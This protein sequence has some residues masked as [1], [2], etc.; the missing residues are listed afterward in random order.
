MIKVYGAKAF[1]PELKG[2]IRDIRVTWLLEEL[3]VPYE[4]TVLDPVT[5]ENRT[6]E[7]LALNPTGKVPTL[8]DGETVLFE[9]GAICE[10]L[11]EKYGQLIPERN[12][13]AYY[14]ARQW[15][16]WFLTN[17]EPQCLRIF[18]SDYFI[19]PGQTAAEIKKM[20]LETLP[21]LLGVLEDRLTRHEFMLQSGFSVTDILAV[22][23]LMGIFHCEILKGYPHIRTYL[24][25]CQSRP[26]YL[27]AFTQNGE[28]RERVLSE[29][30]EMVADANL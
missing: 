15:N 29:Q 9:S 5:G 7:Y 16:Y 10:Y 28:A 8:V 25:R 30:V 2:K 19:E 1:R 17:L 11:A 3:G 20:A 6:P 23:S 12:S 4:R 24:D 26:A 22:T 21:R 18:S 14:E 27:K 13:R